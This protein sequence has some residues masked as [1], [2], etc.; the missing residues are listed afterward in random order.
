MESN[1]WLTHAMQAGKTT[2][3]YG[4]LLELQ[5][6]HD[7]VIVGAKISASLVDRTSLTSN[8]ASMSRTFEALHAVVHANSKFGSRLDSSGMYQ[9][10]H[11]RQ[12]AK[13]V[14]TDKKCVLCC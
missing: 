11:A 3:R 4:M 14:A 12:T 6:R 8:N 9:Y 10:L 2:T 5:Y 7:G 1:G 13:E